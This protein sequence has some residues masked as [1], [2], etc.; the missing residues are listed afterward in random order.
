MF[1]YDSYLHIGALC[2]LAIALDPFWQGDAGSGFYMTPI[3]TLEPF[4]AWRL[5]LTPSGRGMP[6]RVFI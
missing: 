5:P 6:D 1:L 2:R 3:C 4:A